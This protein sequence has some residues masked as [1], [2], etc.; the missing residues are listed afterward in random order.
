MD[1]EL[2]NLLRAKK[3]TILKKWFDAVADTYPD[4]TSS[5][6]KKQKAQFTNP[7][8]YTLSEGLEGLFEALLKGVIPDAVATFLDSI[9]RIRA[10][11]EFSPSEAVSFVFLLKKIVR[12]ELGSETLAQ[13][14][15]RDELAAFDSSVDDLAL[16]AFDLYMKCREKIY[17]LKAN[18]ARNMTFRLLQQAKLIVDNQD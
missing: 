17:E 2:K 18:E 12:Q 8:G 6:L 1:M 16:Y 11:Q 15:L 13:Q 7:V 14:R 9:I 10:I 3:S 4:N 5:F